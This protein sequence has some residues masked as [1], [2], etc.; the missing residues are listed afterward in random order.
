MKSELLVFGSWM[1]LETHFNISGTSANSCPVETAYFTLQK[2][3]SVYIL[4]TN[5]HKIHK[6]LAK[7]WRLIFKSS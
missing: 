3:R 7:I 4:L 5:V 1:Y 6:I 2:G